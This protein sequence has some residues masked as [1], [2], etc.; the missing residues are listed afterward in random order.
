M[1]RLALLL[2][3]ILVACQAFG[4]ENGT[5]LFLGG[6]PDATIRIK[7]HSTGAADVEVTILAA[8]YPAVLLKQ[9]MEDLGTRLGNAPRGLTVYSDQIRG[10]SAKLAFL[11]AKFAVTGL[12]DRANSRLNMTPLIQAFAGAPDPY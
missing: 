1:L 5:S 11:K 9:Q 12:I 3:T 2:A 10:A 7:E 4:Q 8:D 6:R